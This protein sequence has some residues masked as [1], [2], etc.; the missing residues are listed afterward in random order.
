[1]E[2]DLATALPLRDVLFENGKCAHI[3]EPP[4][5]ASP[6]EMVNALHLPNYEEVIVVVG[7]ADSFKTLSPEQ[8]ARLTQL[9]TRG[10]AR[11]AITA[12]A[13]IIDGGTKSGVMELMGMGVADRGHQTPLIGI[14]P[15]GIVT[16]KD[17]PNPPTTQAPVWLDENHSHFILVP[18]EKFGKESSSIMAMAA[19]LVKPSQPPGDSAT[20]GKLQNEK[21]VLVVLIGG[22]PNGVTKTDILLAVRRSFPIVVL[23]QS[24][25]LADEIAEWKNKGGLIPDP[26]LAEI[27]EDGNLH[28][29]DG[30][31]TVA[32]LERLIVRELGVNDTLQEAWRRYGAYN[33]KALQLQAS[34]NRIQP[35]ILGLGA[36]IAFFIALRATFLGG[37]DFNPIR[38]IVDGLIIALPILTSGLLA[39]SGKFNQGSRWI[40]YRAAAEG[41]KRAIF[42]YRTRPAEFR[43][44]PGDLPQGLAQ[45]QAEE[46]TEITRETELQR[47]VQFISSQLMQSDANAAGL[48]LYD[49]K[50]PPET[51]SKKQYG[52]LKDDGISPLTPARYIDMRLDDQIKFFRKRTV[53]NENEYHF[54][55]VLALIAGGLGTFLAA[56]G[57]QLWVTV[58]TALAT[59]FVAY[60]ENRQTHMTIVHYNQT[61]TNLENVKIWWTALSP[62]EQAEQKN[63]EQL[64][65]ATEE[66][67]S[68]ETAGWVQQMQDALGK[69]RVEQ[70]KPTDGDANGAGASQDSTKPTE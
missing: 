48:S 57:W 25:G 27:V 1:M 5:A 26:Q 49:G 50:I 43:A 32:A 59:A 7:W 18:G 4:A 70:A 34:F 58:T 30:N 3:L 65:I 55:Q 19:E 14:A 66:I 37:T 67:L 39:Y 2:T 56:I 12:Q 46:T 62:E 15:R 61:A 11:A 45:A 31:K 60:L 9:C 28:I 42:I 64:V 63:I 16:F 33:A 41:V 35:I 36:V 69:L 6:E 24:G 23:A 51:S 52:G 21:S 47:R 53:T 54:W 10:I 44:K 68:A 13:L 22:N 20:N 40:V 17:D 38:T 8:Q 29:F